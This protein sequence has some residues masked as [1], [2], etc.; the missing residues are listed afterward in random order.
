MSGFRVLV[1]GGNLSAELTGSAGLLFAG[2]RESTGELHNGRVLTAE[3]AAS[4]RGTEHTPVRLLAVALLTIGAK[5][6]SETLSRG[7]R[8]VA[9]PALWARLPLPQRGPALER[10]LTSRCARQNAGPSGQ[11]KQAP[12]SRAGCNATPFAA[13]RSVPAARREVRSAACARTKSPRSGYETGVF[14]PSD[15]PA[16]P[17]RLPDRVPPRQWSRVAALAGRC[18]RW[19]VLGVRQGET[20][21]PTAVRQASGRVQTE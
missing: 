8:S 14:C 12:D 15:R 6:N 17:A 20:R 10:A 2:V 11:Q 1:V 13:Q 21:S 18:A 16:R 4:A 7:F 5:R 3:R 9:N 19:W